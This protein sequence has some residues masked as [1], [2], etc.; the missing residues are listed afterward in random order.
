MLISASNQISLFDLDTEFDELTSHK[1]DQLFSLF[2][3]FID[4]CVCNKNLS[5]MAEKFVQYNKVTLFR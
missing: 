1:P 4:T 2:N 5:K 3:Q